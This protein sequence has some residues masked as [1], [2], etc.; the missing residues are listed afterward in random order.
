MGTGALSVLAGIS[1][2]RSCSWHSGPPKDECNE[3]LFSRLNNHANVSSSLRD[4]NIFNKIL[5][6]Q[7]KQVSYLSLFQ[8]HKKAC[9]T[10]RKAVTGE[11]AIS[12]APLVSFT[13]IFTI[14]CGF[15]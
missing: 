3:G 11:T 14:F 2:F 15:G 5:L 6:I 10:S 9:G 7:I 12:L 1:F 4:L 13:N 8:K